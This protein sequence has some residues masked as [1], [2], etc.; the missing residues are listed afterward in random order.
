MTPQDKAMLAYIGFL[1][2][3]LVVGAILAWRMK[4]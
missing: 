4:P 1:F 2:V 3:G